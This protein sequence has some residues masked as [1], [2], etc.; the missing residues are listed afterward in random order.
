M[1]KYIRGKLIGRTYSAGLYIGKI[2]CKVPALQPDFC[3]ADVSLPYRIYEQISSAN[4][5]RLTKYS[6]TVISLK[7]GENRCECT[8]FHP[9]QRV[10]HVGD[11]CCN[12]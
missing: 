3:F 11:W 6:D 5:L 7:V 4:K 1:G 2:S 12:L 9:P 10:Y 8:D